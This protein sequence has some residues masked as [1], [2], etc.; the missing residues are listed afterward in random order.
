M[1]SHLRSLEKK[2]KSRNNNT[3]NTNNNNNNN[4][5]LTIGFAVASDFLKNCLTSFRSFSV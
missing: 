4:I 2:E 1:L 3:N 5:I